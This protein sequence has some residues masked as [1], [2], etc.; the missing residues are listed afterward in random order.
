MHR[1][2]APVLFKVEHAARYP[3]HVSRRIHQRHATGS[4]TWLV[5]P[6]SLHHEL[7]RWTARSDYQLVW[8]SPKDYLLT[9]RAVVHGS[10]IQALKVLVRALQR[11]GSPVRAVLYRKNRVLIIH[12]AAGR[13]R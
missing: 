7:R 2:G 9:T 12:R 3:F 5:F 1:N 4:R 10:F 8:K 6:G 13:F 11:A